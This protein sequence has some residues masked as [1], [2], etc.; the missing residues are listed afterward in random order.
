M[1]YLLLLFTILEIFEITNL[2]IYALLSL[3]VFLTNYLTHSQNIS[4]GAL[5]S[6]HAFLQLSAILIRLLQ[7]LMANYSPSARL[8]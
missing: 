5:S 7:Y 2:L 6:P 1:I 3:Y 4:W 8:L